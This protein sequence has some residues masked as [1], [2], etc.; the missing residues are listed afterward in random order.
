MS[1]KTKPL[2][3]AISGKLQQKNSGNLRS[4]LYVSSSLATD[5]PFAADSNVGFG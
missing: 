4:G 1:T 2:N 5:V 3:S